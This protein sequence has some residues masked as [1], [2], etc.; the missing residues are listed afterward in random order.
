MEN[1]SKNQIEQFLK[2]EKEIDF[3]ADHSEVSFYDQMEDASALTIMTSM[4]YN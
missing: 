4:T 2:L 1:L 3:S